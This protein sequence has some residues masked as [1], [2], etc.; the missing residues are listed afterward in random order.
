MLHDARTRFSE[1]PQGV[2]R[3]V[4]AFLLF[5]DAN[6]LGTLNGYGSLN[7]LDMLLGDA[8]PNDMVWLI[9]LIESI[10]AGFVVIKVLFDDVQS[11][12]LRTLGLLLSPFFMVAVTFYSLDLLLQG[13]GASAGFT[14]DLVS[15]TTGTLTWSSTYLAIAIGLTLTYKVQRYGNF[16]Q[17]ELFMIGIVRW[18]LG[19]DAHWFA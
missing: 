10:T 16:A 4:F 1:L 6:Y 17:S 19:L 3:L 2:R 15:I 9:Q 8:L 12:P 11:S 7:I 14:L 5:V 18:R 13:L